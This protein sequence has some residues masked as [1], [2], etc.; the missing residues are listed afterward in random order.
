MDADPTLPPAPPAVALVLLDVAHLQKSEEKQEQV[1]QVYR[2]GHRERGG[3]NQ[4]GR[5]EWERGNLLE[6]AA[7]TPPFRPA[8]ARRRRRRVAALVRRPGS[9]WVAPACVRRVRECFCAGG[10]AVRSG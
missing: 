8:A 4:R 10:V 9:G 6:I 7:G 5:R 2:S 3:G 1:S